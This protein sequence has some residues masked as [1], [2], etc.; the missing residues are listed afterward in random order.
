MT[1]MR[2]VGECFF[3][4]RLTRVF[5]DKFHRAVKRL[6]VCV[7]V[8]SRELCCWCSESAVAC[9]SSI[10]KA[11]KTLSSHVAADCSTTNH[12]HSTCPDSIHRTTGSTSASHCHPLPLVVAKQS[13]YVCH[14]CHKFLI[15]SSIAR[16]AKRTYLTYSESNF[17]VFAPQWRHVP[18]LGWNLVNFTPFSAMI[19]V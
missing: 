7:C 18:S 13:K 4:Y 16:N 14:T 17:E 1:T 8:C 15:T 6:C 12:S 10:A 19:R 2:V 9:H 5:P 3:W 11:Q